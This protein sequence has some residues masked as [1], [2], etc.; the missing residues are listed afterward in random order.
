MGH[1]KKII[2]GHFKKGLTKKINLFTFFI[3]C[4]LIKLIKGLVKTFTFL[5]AFFVDRSW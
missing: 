5:L 4:G 2:M 1:F 3:F